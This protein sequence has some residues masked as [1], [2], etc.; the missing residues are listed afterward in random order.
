MADGLSVEVRG[1]DRLSRS[2]AEAADAFQDL[3]DVNRRAAAGVAQAA[4]PPRLTGALA[5]SIRVLDANVREGVA[6][7]S[8]V[9]AGVIEH[10]WPAR[11]IEG[12]G[13]MAA[14]LDARYAATVDLYADHVDRTLATV[15]GI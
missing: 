7:S 4:R 1:A 3:I 6:G 9:Y 12:A 10:G 14:A 11:G 5:A 8:L 15:K 2:A 13:Y